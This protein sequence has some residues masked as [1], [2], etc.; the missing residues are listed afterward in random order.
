[1]PTLSEAGVVS[2]GPRQAKSG[3][4]FT[5][6]AALLAAVTCRVRVPTMGDFPFA[7]LA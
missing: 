5:Y 3:S 7:H 4:C 2:V 6:R 1:M